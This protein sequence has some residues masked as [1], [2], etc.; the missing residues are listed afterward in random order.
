MSLGTDDRDDMRRPASLIVALAILAGCTV[1]T[2]PIH[3]GAG[4][5]QSS[6]ADVGTPVQGVV[7][8]LQ[9][10]P[11]DRIT[12]VSAESVGVADGASTKLYVSPAVLEASGDWLTGSVLEELAGAE[13]TAKSSTAGP[14]NQVGIVA[15]MTAS[16]PGRY[17]LTAVRLTYRLNSGQERVA[18]GADVIFTLCAGRPL[19]AGCEEFASQP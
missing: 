16:R 10:R 17:Q 15:E 3:A 7:L 4:S 8:F 19:P 11:G 1:D 6:I 18:E 5:S 12:F 13:F 2:Y 14:E 9:L